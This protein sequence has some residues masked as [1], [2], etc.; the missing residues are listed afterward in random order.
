MMMAKRLSSVLS[1]EGVVIKSEIREH[2]EEQE[3]G[4]VI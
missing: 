1:A 4:R 2:G 3:V